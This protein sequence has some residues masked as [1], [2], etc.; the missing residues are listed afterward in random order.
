MA[1][2]SCECR[3]VFY[4]KNN[5]IMNNLLYK[6]EESNELS[7]IE[8]SGQGSTIQGDLMTHLIRRYIRHAERLKLEGDEDAAEDM[9]RKHIERTGAKI[10]KRVEDLYS[11]LGL[12]ENNMT[13]VQKGET[14]IVRLQLEHLEMSKQQAEQRD[15]ELSNF[16]RTM[17]QTKLE[18]LSRMDAERIEINRLLQIQKD[19][20]MERWDREYEE[21]QQKLK[22]LEDLQ[23]RRRQL[24]AEK[25]A[26][27]AKIKAEEEQRKAGDEQRAADD[28][29]RSA[30]DEQAAGDEQ[31]AAD[32][33][34][35]AVG[36]AQRAAADDKQTASDDAQKAT[37]DIQ[38]DLDDVDDEIEKKIQE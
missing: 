29:E 19:E 7:E 12:V 3:I 14:D 2:E 20:M 11:R 16:M 22:E 30:D 25:A 36:D 8:S 9:M 24:Q 5:V 38:K 17:D 13:G 37:D 34:Q 23:V 33:K 15:R 27:E 28:K 31:K 1:M 26:Q 21:R 10:E 6:A 35:S 18:L 4:L 32:D